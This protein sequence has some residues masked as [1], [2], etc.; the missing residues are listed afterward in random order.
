MAVKISLDGTYSILV[1]GGTWFHSGNTFFRADGR[2]FSM[3]DGSL[4]L[5]KTSNISGSDVIGDWQSWTYHYQAGSSLIDASVIR[6]T[7]PKLPLVL[8]RQLQKYVNGANN[9]KAA[10][11]NYVI[12]SFPTFKVESGSVKRG[13]LSYG[14]MMFGDTHKKM[15]E[16]GG[17][18]TTLNSGYTSGPLAVFD[19]F[20]RTVIISPASKFMS[21][22]MW[23]ESL[24]GIGGTVHWGIMG[25]AD[26]IPPEHQLDIII[27]YGAEGINKA[28]EGWGEYLRSRYNRHQRF[29]DSDLTVTHLGYW[30]DNGAYYYYN[31]ENG[32][33][34]QQTILDVVAGI[35]KSGVPFRYMQYDSWWYYKGV[36][37]G[38]KTWEYIPSV[39]PD[40]M[41]YVYNKTGMPVSAHNRYWASDTTYAIQNGGK[42][43]FLI[44]STKSL[45]TDQNFWNALL[46]K[47][48]KWGLVTYEQDWLCD[49]S[50]L[51]VLL[52]DISLGEMWLKQMGNAAAKNGI[53]IQYCMSNSRHALTAL[54]IPVV[55]QIRVSGDY[56]PG[57]DQ[58][59]IGVS[60]MLSHAVGLAPFKDTFWTTSVQ[61][62]NPYGKTEPNAALN[63]AVAT[64]STGPVGPSDMI[65]ALNTSLIM[66]SVNA[67]GLILKPSR[68]ATAIDAQI[69]KHPCFILKA[70]VSSFDGPRGEVWSTYSHVAGL[71]FGIIL[72]ADLP[73]DYN[74]TPRLAG[75]PEMGPAMAFTYTNPNTLKEFN[76]T[77]PI[78][79]RGCSKVD[80]CM[81]YVT[82]LLPNAFGITTVILG[83]L[84]KWVPVSPQRVTN[85]MVDDDV[86]VRVTGAPKEAI[87]FW[88]AVNNKPLLV[89]CIL[90]NSGFATIRL[91]SLNC[92]QE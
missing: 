58:W 54:E 44:Q 47:A 35:R 86:T 73:T 92:F 2:S 68:P 10:N 89:K 56:H 23:H 13:Y 78:K 79:L 31:P 4:K 70:A 30:T 46:N 38:V 62:G 51:D 27:Y 76:E 19:K 81:H 9:T 3:K 12:S 90:G 8:F 63:A 22:S 82:P 43:L 48:R 16:W 85:I 21:A 34:F 39:F 59:K 75:F 29:V 45:P 67:D 6:Y 11:Q 57:K 42:Y 17:L 50:G 24:F 66:R 60:S 91:H 14:G 74:I 77:S 15:G 18:R 69:M 40:G 80:F 52:T 26:P 32:T 55:T 72:A 37:N 83:E 36:G 41:Q 64:L 20:G 33:N 5:L 71:T 25:Y 88:F 84:D 87:N 49:I 28:F 61:P 53:T 7:T 65:G 1:N